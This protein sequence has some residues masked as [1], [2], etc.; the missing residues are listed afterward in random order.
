M[1][2]EWI[3][4]MRIVLPFFFS[5]L[6]SFEKYGMCT[7]TGTQNSNKKWVH[8]APFTLFSK[9]KWMMCVC[10][11]RRQKMTQK[12]CSSNAFQYPGCRQYMLICVVLYET[13]TYDKI[14]LH[15]LYVPSRL[16]SFNWLRLRAATAHRCSSFHIHYSR[17]VFWIEIWSAT[18]V[19]SEMFWLRIHR[20]VRILLMFAWFG[21]ARAPFHK[22]CTH[23]VYFRP[24]L[25][26]VVR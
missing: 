22:L 6:S 7:G 21:R 25:H 24:G 9:C 4:C 23:T 20:N 2:I 5:S 26:P 17:S 3:A 11:R 1:E 8:F 19:F 14:V 12:C 13:V 15:H 18:H 16:I 10:S